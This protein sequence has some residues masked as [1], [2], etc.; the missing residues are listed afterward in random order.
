MLKFYEN[1]CG[2]IKMERLRIYLTNEFKYCTLTCTLVR[3]RNKRVFPTLQ[4]GL[5]PRGRGGGGGG[6]GGI[7]SIVVLS[8]HL[9]LYLKKSVVTPYWLSA[10]CMVC[11]SLSDKPKLVSFHPHPQCDCMS[12]SGNIYMDFLIPGIAPCCVMST[13]IFRSK[14]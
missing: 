4:N 8:R 14:L 1:E 13:S 7:L 3:G 2:F 11:F 5:V 12:K 9:N 6:G 10:E